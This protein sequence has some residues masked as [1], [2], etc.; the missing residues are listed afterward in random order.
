MTWLYICCIVSCLVFNYPFSQNEVD[1]LYSYLK[2]FVASTEADIQWRF[3][4]SA[5]DKAKS[6]T[7][8]TQRKDLMYEAF[9]AA[10]LALKLGEANYACHKVLRI[11][12]DGSVGDRYPIDQ[13]MGLMH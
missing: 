7:D 11:F 1:Q 3:A 12:L 10:E 2:Q 13:S 9:A 6:T 4:R 8:K 5:C